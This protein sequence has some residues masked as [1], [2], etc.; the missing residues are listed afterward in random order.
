MHDVQ[1]LFTETYIHTQV[2]LLNNHVFHTHGRHKHA[3][4]SRHNKRIRAYIHT[5]IH[6]YMRMYSPTRKCIPT[7]SLIPAICK[8]QIPPQLN[9]LHVCVS[10]WLPRKKGRE[11][12]MVRP[13]KFPIV[14]M[15]KNLNIYMHTCIHAYMHTLSCWMIF[16][17]VKFEIRI[18]STLHGCM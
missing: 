13:L 10:I 18:E 17:R 15:A 8:Y 11:S 1:I 3:N 6:T 12:V 7:R 9:P 14:C 5:Y 4:L 16:C 2:G